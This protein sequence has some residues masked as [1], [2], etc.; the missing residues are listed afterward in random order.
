MHCCGNKQLDEELVLLVVYCIWC[1]VP[2]KPNLNLWVI[3][4]AVIVLVEQIWQGVQ[5]Y[6][7]KWPLTILHVGD[8]CEC[9]EDDFNCAHDKTRRRPRFRILCRDYLTA[10]S[11]PPGETYYD[12]LLDVYAALFKGD[13]SWRS[14]STVANIVTQRKWYGNFSVKSHLSL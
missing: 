4:I 3:C 2:S 14:Q 8:V 9:S 7:R 11:N 12:S 5:V 1:I 13:A 10:F 6:F